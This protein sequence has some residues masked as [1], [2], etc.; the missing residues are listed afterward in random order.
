MRSEKDI[1]RLKQNKILWALFRTFSWTLPLAI[2]IFFIYAFIS[3]NIVYC[4]WILYQSNYYYLSIAYSLIFNIFLILAFV[5]FIK[6]VFTE[7]GL[8]PPSFSNSRS[9]TFLEDN[10]EENQEQNEEDNNENNNNDSDK[11]ICKKCKIERPVRAHHCHLCGVCKLRMDHHC[12][13][14]NNCVGFYNY[15]FFVLLLTHASILSIWAFITI[16]LKLFFI[17]FTVSYFIPS[18]FNLE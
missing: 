18:F 3:Y 17:P 5:S 7:G 13:A 9:N 11:I 16:L 4:Y 15:K 2:T 1:E 12:P 10:N 8:V 14:L 6:A